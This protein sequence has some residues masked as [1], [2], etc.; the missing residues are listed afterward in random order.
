MSDSKVYDVLPHAAERAL[1]DEAAYQAM[2]SRSIEDPEGFWADMASEH[3]DWFRKVGQGRGLEL[4]GR[5]RHPLVRRCPKV[6]VAWNCLDRHLAER[7]D[8]PAI[9][10]EGRPAG[11]RAAHHLPGAAHGGLQARQRA[12]VQGSRRRATASASTCRWCPRQWWRC[13]PARGSAPCTRWCSAD[14][15]RMRCATASSIPTAGW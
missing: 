13:S 2:Y 4:R 6:N 7:G 3:V 8:K 10:W 11:R 5:R 14:S 9:L 12:E 15:L 1:I